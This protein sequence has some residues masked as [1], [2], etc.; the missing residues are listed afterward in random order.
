MDKARNPNLIRILEA[1]GIFISSQSVERMEQTG[2]I[3]S[4][5]NMS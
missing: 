1:Q 3:A 5:I 2:N 4:E